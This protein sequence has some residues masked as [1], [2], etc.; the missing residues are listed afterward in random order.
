MSSETALRILLIEDNMDD[1]LLV[2]DLFS[3]I[4]GRRFEVDWKSSYEEALSAAFQKSYDVIFLDH[5]LGKKTGSEWVREASRKGLQ[6]PVILLVET[7]GEAGDRTAPEIGVLDFLVKGQIK[8]DQLERSIRYAVKHKKALKRSL[9]QEERLRSTL[10]TVL[11]GVIT[12]DEKG[13]ILSFNPAA[14]KMFGYTADEAVGKNVRILMPPLFRKEH[15]GYLA[16]YLRTGEKKII[17]IGREVVGK[18]KDG[19]MFPMDLAVGE[20]LIENRPMFTG[21]VRDISQQ[22]RSEKAQATRLRYEKG[23]SDCSRTLL[24]ERGDADPIPEAVSHILEAAQ[25]GRIGI[26]DFTEVGE[27][28]ISGAKP[29]YEICSGGIPPEDA[30]PH[31][32]RIPFLPGLERWGDLLSKGKMVYGGMKTFPESERKIFSTRGV[33]SLLAVPVQIRQGWKGVVTFHDCANDR[34]WPDEDLRLLHTVAYVLGSY[35]NRRRNR[36]LL[37][38]QATHDP[39]TGLYNRRFFTDR[40][41]MEI[42]TSRRYRYPLSLC[43]CDL[44]DFKSINDRYGHGAGDEVLVKLGQLIREETR[45]EDIPGRMGG[46]EFCVILPHTSSFTASICLERIRTRLKAFPFKTDDGKEFT[47]SATFGVA[48]FHPPAKTQKE[49]FER[50]DQAL[51]RGKELGRNTVVVFESNR[52]NPVEGGG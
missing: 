32:P 28:K 26:L 17:G 38:H 20:V 12:I 35:L 3:K 25:L 21:V 36:E 19:S 40:L 10:N 27:I 49:L 7:A 52:M 2:K 4:Q 14:Q 23:L 5:S 18:R 47:A 48:E 16:N 6:T 9:E 31:T 33:R 41:E 51:Y 8:P 46:D 30:D 44:D 29:I 13:T 45:A 1:Y 43:I 24:E 15:D 11:D 39:L 22:K 50:A 37:E 42:K 34:K